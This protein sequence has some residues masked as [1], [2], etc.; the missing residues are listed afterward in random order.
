MSADV[1][2]IISG[3]SKYTKVILSP[4][5][6]FSLL[7]HIVFRREIA[8]HIGSLASSLDFSEFSML[9][10]APLSQIYYNLG[11]DLCTTEYIFSE[12]KITQVHTILE[13]ISAALVKVESI[14]W[15]TGNN[16]TKATCA[17]YV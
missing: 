16:E 11:V 4:E 17:T 14:K 7:M 13:R 6:L 8:P 9:S 2:E 3:I 1:H 10:G 15:L 5:E 12:E